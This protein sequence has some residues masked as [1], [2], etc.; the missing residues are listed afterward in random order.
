M[1]SAFGVTEVIPALTSDGVFGI[2]RMRTPL[3]LVV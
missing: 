3:S 2:A 1:T